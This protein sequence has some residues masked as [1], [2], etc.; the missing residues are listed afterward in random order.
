MIDL[1][2]TNTTTALPIKLQPSNLRPLVFRTL[3]KKHGLNVNTE[4]LSI[5]T[6]TI[7]LKFGFDW[8]SLQSQ[9]FLEEIAKFWKL[10]DRGIFIDGNGL[11]AVL[12]EIQKKD[13]TVQMQKAGR[14]NTVVDEIV[15]EDVQLQWEDYFQFV[16]PLNQPRSL[17]DKSRKHFDVYLTKERLPFLSKLTLNTK[18]QVE[19]QN[20]HYFL[21]MDRLSRNENF[22]KASMTSIS[23]LNSLTIDGIGKNNEITLIKNMLGRDGQKFLLFG[24]LSKNSTDEYILE[25]TT[26]YIE[27][28]LNQA[29]KNQGS[30]YCIGMFVLAEGIYSASGGN[31]NQKQDYMGGCFYVSNLAQ[32]PAERRDKS[33]DVY[34]H[35]DFLGIHKHMVPTG[36]KAVKFPKP[37]RKKLLQLEK[38]LQN[39]KIVMMG[40]DLYLDSNKTLQAMQKFFHRLENTIIEALDSEETQSYIPLALIFTGSFTSRPLTSTNSTSDANLSNSE[41]YKGNFDQFA[42]ML[43]EYPNIV[44]RCKIVLIPGDNDPWQSTYSLG[45]SCLNTFPQA[46]I[47]K[48]FVNRLENLLPRGNLIL[49][50]N[51]TR[52]S[53]L[54][55]ELVIIKDKLM[56]K[57]KRNDLMF[58]LELDQIH[59]DGVEELNDKERIDILI[60]SKDERIPN[61]T[62]QARKLVKTL[63]DQGTLQPFKK[64]LKVVN[65]QFEH[66]LR[67]EPLPNAIVLNDCSF[68]NFEVVY[69]GCRVVNLTS[70]INE[71]SRKLNY[72][73]YWPSSKKFEFK[74]LYF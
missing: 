11:K 10:E 65:T 72:L 32:P 9:K 64:D 38:S 71:G 42:K 47:P 31:L 20:N 57:F 16:S 5:L 53:Y 3:T 4:A 39:H 12:K 60:Q 17:F 48:V 55:Q 61:K 43:S 37:F 69:Q 27:L 50:W 66:C 41:L 49:A 1:S 52:L 45:S 54:S 73:E 26:G 67:V 28:N 21:I 70:A 19:S 56:S 24:L 63:L 29:V 8:K 35:L 6:D 13:E 34:G 2:T 59:D 40:S 74:D 62:R 33:L 15:D 36:D 51:P 7:S 18:S 58:P 23:N 14:T 30:F 68:D 46:S 44:Q 22:Q 25:D